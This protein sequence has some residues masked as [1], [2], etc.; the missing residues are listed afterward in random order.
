MLRHNNHFRYHPWEIRL[1]GYRD[2]GSKM[3]DLEFEQNQ[4]PSSSGGTQQALILHLENM[5]TFYPMVHYDCGFPHYHY[6]KGIN[7][8]FVKFWSKSK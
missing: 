8:L 2:S 7:N 6:E 5:G 1:I 4:N 3:Y